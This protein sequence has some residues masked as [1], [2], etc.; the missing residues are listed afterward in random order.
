[1]QRYN[2]FYQIHKGL[3]QMLYHNA[4]Q[5]LQTDFAM[6][7]ETNELIPQLNEV[8]DLFDGHAHTEDHFV[9]PAVETV[10]PGS[11]SLFEEEHK[12][13]HA[14]AG[15][16]RALL[17]MFH[18][19]V[20]GEEKNELGSA[21]RLA[22]TEFLVFNLQHMAKEECALNKILWQH[23]TDD[24]LMSITQQILANIPAGLH[25]KYNTWMM[26]GLSNTEITAWLKNI[27]NLAP[28]LVFNGMLQLAQ[29]ELNAHRWGIV[30]EE[31]TDGAL[32][33]S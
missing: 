17:N 1:M 31:I 14:L 12:Q 13:D 5:L 7:E 16:L 19:T 10:Q 27:R 18:H 24:E 9:L 28:G 21:I 11:A 33:A 20:S 25:T 23:Y 3:R 6:A 29:K 2:I 32:L 30:Q 8:L 4:S 26:R 22:F 15:R